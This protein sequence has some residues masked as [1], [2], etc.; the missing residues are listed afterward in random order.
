M[1]KRIL[2]LVI[3]MT[4]LNCYAEDFQKIILYGWD[5]EYDKFSVEI[6]E[7]KDF[8]QV[9]FLQEQAS[10]Y[11]QILDDGGNC[12]YKEFLNSSVNTEYIVPIGDLYP[13]NYRL[14]LVNE[15]GE[16]VCGEFI[17]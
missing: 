12:V 3:L 9:I 4:S 6:N 8:L 2:L 15:I 11:L 7:E 14:I 1:L 10:L 13:G 5:L 17:K 16:K